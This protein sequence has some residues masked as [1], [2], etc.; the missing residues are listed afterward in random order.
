ML[1][2]RRRQREAVDYRLTALMELIG[3]VINLAPITGQNARV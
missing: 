2:R 3:F 1:C